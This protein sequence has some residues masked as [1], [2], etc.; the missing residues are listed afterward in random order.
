MVDL[1]AYLLE[2]SHDYVCLGHFSS[3][4][5]EKVFGKLRQGSGG[6]YFINVQ[7]VLQ[8]VTI[9][10]TKLLLDLGADFEDLESEY[11]HSCKKCSYLLNGE[12]VTDVFHNQQYGR[13]YF[14]RS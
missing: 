10:K 1:V 13:K 11:G 12:Q 9:R 4:P 14:Q 6:V 2:T 3:D 7:Q 5:I 8:K